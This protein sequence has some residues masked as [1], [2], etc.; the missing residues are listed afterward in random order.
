MVPAADQPV[1]TLKLEVFELAIVFVDWGVL[2]VVVFGGVFGTG[3]QEIQFILNFSDVFLGS[4]IYFITAF[5]VV[6]Q[7]DGVQFV[8]C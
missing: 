3:V 5:L 7:E 8:D 6:L 4:I 2:R 1:E